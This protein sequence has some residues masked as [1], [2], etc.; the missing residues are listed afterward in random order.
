MPKIVGRRE[1]VRASKEVKRFAIGSGFLILVENLELGDL[2]LRLGN[3]LRSKKHVDVVKNRWNKDPQRQVVYFGKDDHFYAGVQHTPDVGETPE[4]QEIREKIAEIRKQMGLEIFDYSRGV[5]NYY[6]NRGIGPHSD[7]N[8]H[9]K[10]QSVASISAGA[11]MV[12]R[13]RQNSEKIL[14]VALSHG[15]VVFMEN[16]NPDDGSIT[17]EVLPKKDSEERINFTLRA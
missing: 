6:Q 13:V 7:S 1:I 10:V 15:S 11:E 17:H 12:F 14:D 3:L 4:I 9:T 8:K 2:V 16:M 5:L